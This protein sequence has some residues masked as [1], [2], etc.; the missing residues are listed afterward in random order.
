MAAIWAALLFLNTMTVTVQIE[1]KERPVIMKR[2]RME[3]VDEPSTSEDE[4]FRWEKLIS[5]P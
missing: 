5:S 3:I 2:S 4:G 1:Q